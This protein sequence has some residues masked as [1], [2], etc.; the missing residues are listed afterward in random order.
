MQKPRR[1]FV[2]VFVGVSCSLSLVSLPVVCASHRLCKLPQDSVGLAF[3]GLCFVL[4]GYCISPATVDHVS[5]HPAPRP[6]E[7]QAYRP[8]DL[9]FCF[10]SVPADLGSP[11]S[12]KDLVVCDY[13]YGSPSKTFWKIIV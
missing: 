12:W 9:E 13:S 4:T 8:W 2:C 6:L 1:V 5:Q 7:A 11:Q 3:G 10:F